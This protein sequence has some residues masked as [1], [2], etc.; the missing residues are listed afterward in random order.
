M[1]GVL[2][3]LRVVEVSAFVAAPLGGVTLAQLGADVIQISDVRGRIDYH[4]WPLADGGASL[5]W[6]ALNKAKRSVRLDLSRPEGQELAQLLVAGSGGSGDGILVSNLPA[7]GWMAYPALASR[8]SDL[9]MLTL[10]G[11]PDGSTAVDYT[12]NCA[13]GF[14]MITGR[15]GEPVNHALPAWDVAAGLYLSVGL[16]AAERHRRMTGQGQLVTLS[17]ADV[18]LSTVANLGYVAEAQVNDAG[19]PPLGNDVYGAFGRDFPTADHRRVMVVAISDRQWRALCAATGLGRQLAM[20]GPM[21]GVDLGEEAGRFHARDA[22]AAV[23]APWFAARSLDQVR[24]AF[25]GSGVLWGVF[26][27]FKQLVAEDPRCSLDNPMFQRLHQPGI[28]DVLASHTPLGFG[29]VPRDRLRPAPVLGEHTD[30]V[31]ADVLGLPDAEIGRLHD[32]GIVAG[33]VAA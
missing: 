23:L 15:G 13:G 11:N 17:L 8:R 3:G 32:Q 22:I 1:S 4:R 20:V 25:D 12:V 7:R 6:T 31:L 28:G 21:M 5:Y 26:Q 29:A 24:S 10:T 19:R 2:S 9:I 27:D 16:L 30:H 33:P 18:M 14:P